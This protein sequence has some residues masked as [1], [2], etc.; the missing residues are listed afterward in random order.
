MVTVLGAALV[1]RAGIDYIKK[2][3]SKRKRMT[4]KSDV[5]EFAHTLI[6]GDFEAN[7]RYEAKL[8]A[9]GWD[10]WPSFLSALFFLAVERRFQGRYD[11]AEVI[12][13]V[14]DL[15][16]ETVDKSAPIDAASVESLIKSCVRTVRTADHGPGDYGQ[17]RTI[18][19]YRIL[20]N[21]NLTDDELH[22]CSL[23]SPSR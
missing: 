5:V 17:L 14:A 12:R 2:R 9:E 11:E 4:I 13:F 3:L 21:E 19:S 15:R 18:V 6:R 22:N 8:D 7:D 20:A 1:G 16:A 23:D 10:G